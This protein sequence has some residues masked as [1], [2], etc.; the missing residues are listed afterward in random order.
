MPPVLPRPAQLGSK[1]VAAALS[2]NNRERGYLQSGS[3]GLD[4]IERQPAVRLPVDASFGS[5]LPTRARLCKRPE[6]AR[7]E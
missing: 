4:D 2:W 6:I 7:R 1:M 3:A 5:R